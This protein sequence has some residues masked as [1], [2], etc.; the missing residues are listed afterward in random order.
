MQKPCIPASS[1]F[2][3][4]LRVVSR[5]GTVTK[6]NAIIAIGIALCIKRENKKNGKFVN[7]FLQNY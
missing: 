2:F 7:A 4:F 5:H 3:K 6:V 1:Y